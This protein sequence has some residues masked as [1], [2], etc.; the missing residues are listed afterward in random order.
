MLLDLT[1]HQEAL[2]WEQWATKPPLEQV[3]QQWGQ[4]RAGSLAVY[5]VISSLGWGRRG[6]T[7]VAVAHAEIL[8]P[9]SWAGPASRHLLTLAK[10]LM[11]V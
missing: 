10:E 6:R 1:T 5:G 8:S 2:F 7:L 4:F 3:G 9:T 11:S